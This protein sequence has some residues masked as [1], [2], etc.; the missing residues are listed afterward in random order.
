MKEDSE[1]HWSF[2]LLCEP[3]Y[4]QLSRP[5]LV[6]VKFDATVRDKANIWVKTIDPGDSLRVEAKIMILR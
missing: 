5:G 2:A 1:W 4:G 3:I 6:K